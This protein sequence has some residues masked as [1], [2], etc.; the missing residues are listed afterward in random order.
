MTDKR[1]KK[2]RKELKTLLKKYDAYIT[3]GSG[4]GSDWHG[5]IGE[6]FQVSFGNETK[7][8]QLTDINSFVLSAYELKLMED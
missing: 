3:V 5:I 8:N 2:F 7:E 6:H 1:L 4:P